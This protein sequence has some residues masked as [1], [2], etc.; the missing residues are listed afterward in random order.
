MLAVEGTQCPGPV[1]KTW[2]LTNMKVAQRSHRSS[3]PNEIITFFGLF[4]KLRCLCIYI[5]GERGLVEWFYK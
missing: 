5:I 2:K 3:E 4:P 1:K